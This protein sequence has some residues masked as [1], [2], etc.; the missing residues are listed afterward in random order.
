[1]GNA[2]L[3]YGKEEGQEIKAMTLIG[4]WGVWEGGGFTYGVV[5]R[6]PGGGMS[7]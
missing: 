3:E 6:S 2:L 4:F 1:V 5:S 7:V